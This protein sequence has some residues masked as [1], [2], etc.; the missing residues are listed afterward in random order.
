MMYVYQPD[1]V[2]ARNL[3]VDKEVYALLIYKTMA[4]P[5]YLRFTTIMQVHCDNPRVQ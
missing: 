5:Q 1:R 3:V 2:T 4:V